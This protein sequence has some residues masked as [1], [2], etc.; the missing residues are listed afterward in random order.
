MVGG[1]GTSGSARIVS[2]GGRLSSGSVPLRTRFGGG[3]GGLVLITGGA[4]AGTSSALID[5]GSDPGLLTYAEISVAALASSFTR[6][7][8]AADRA[9][10]SN[11]AL[12]N[13]G[14]A[15]AYLCASHMAVARA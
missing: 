8:S 13:S 5:S 10:A 7:S 12:S 6:G 4:G 14:S 2:G 1:G 11:A 15:S 3:G 9:L